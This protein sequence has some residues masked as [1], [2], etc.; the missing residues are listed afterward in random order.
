[1]ETCTKKIDFLISCFGKNY[2][3]A[4]DGVNVAFEC[5]SCGK[6]S[7]KLKFS[8]SLDNW[9]CHCWVCNLKGKNPYYIIKNFCGEQKSQEFKSTFNLKIGNKDENAIEVREIIR[10]PGQFQLIA[11]QL[12]SRDPDTR[13]C[14]KYLFSRGVTKEQLW[15]HK[16]GTIVGRGWHRRVV[17]PSFDKNQTLDFYVSRSIDKDAFIKYQN[18][19]SDKTK[20]VFDEIR[21]DWNKE[22]TI[23]EGVFDMIKSG[24]NTACLLG[25]SLFESHKL[26][27]KII[28]H[29]TPVLLA[30]DAD[31]T[32]KS[33]DIARELTSFGIQVRILNCDGYSDIGDMPKEIMRQKSLEAHIYSQESRLQHL[34]GTINS[35]SIF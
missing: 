20:I 4:R 7:G 9:Y 15:Y 2:H 18:C 5:P 11:T 10:F 12:N 1:M 33:Y 19:K 22:L 29:K 14:L 28:K 8:V 16:I 24:P 25:S 27:Q 32:K 6:G 13:D 35:G 21:I 31:M 17:F 34:I 30:L 3:L 23:V 26:F